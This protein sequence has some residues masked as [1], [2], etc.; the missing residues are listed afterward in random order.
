[1]FMA[2]SAVTLQAALCAVHSPA[3]RASAPAV[4]DVRQPPYGAKCDWDGKRGTD[5]TAAFEVAAAAASA[6]YR[7]TGKPVEVR[8]GTSCEIASTVSFG[9]GVHWTGPGTIYVPNQTR[10]VFL[11]RNADDVSVAD[12]TIEVLD[13]NCGAN[14]ATCS[15]IRWESTADDSQAHRHVSVRNN[16]I[17]HA[18]WGILIGYAAGRGSLSDVEIKGNVISSPSP[19][20]DADAIHVG[21][22][23]HHFII[24]DNKAFNRGDAGVAASSEL[25]DYTCSDGRIEGN[26]LIEDQVGLDNSGCTNTLWKGNF[27]RATTPPRGSNPAFRSITYLG[28]TSSNV[29]ALGNYLQ[30]GSGFGEYAAKVDEVAGQ[31]GTN[32]SLWGNTIVSPRSLYLRGSLMEVAGNTFAA[33]NSTLTIDYDGA[34]AVPTGSISIGRNRWLGAGT[35]RNGSNHNLLTHLS[36]APQLITLPLVYENKDIF[37]TRGEGKVTDEAASGSSS[38]TA[39]LRGQT[40][41]VDGQRLAAGYCLSATAHVRGAVG[42][43]SARVADTGLTNWPEEFI[44]WAFVSSQ[45]IVTVRTC[46]MQAGVFPS[47]TFNVI[48][49]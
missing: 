36:L 2:L 14:N 33:N 7:K 11:A 12:I 34:H 4:V 15:A 22:R 19:Y 39:M 16:T 20:M 49:Q 1:M 38:P 26:V 40:S 13:Q 27:V 43:M 44:A 46:A 48:V 31:R 28:L 17:H 45:D 5:D 9:S 47:V 41:R 3:A 18:N 42:S 25:G 35:V 8:V 23:V 32:A 30:N 10:Q 29:T 21:G 37:T 24:T 6:G